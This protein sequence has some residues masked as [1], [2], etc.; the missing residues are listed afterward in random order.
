MAFSCP[1]GGSVHHSDVKRCQN[2]LQRFVVTAGE[3]TAQTTSLLQPQV[4]LAFSFSAA[5]YCGHV[6]RRF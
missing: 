2:R 1:D 4:R 3:A 6:H 5:D